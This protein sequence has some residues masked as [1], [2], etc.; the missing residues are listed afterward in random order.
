MQETGG[1]TG[2]YVND[3]K[4]SSGELKNGDVIRMGSAILLFNHYRQREADVEAGRCRQCCLC[5]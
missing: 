2:V 5:L 4:I 1:G 3:R